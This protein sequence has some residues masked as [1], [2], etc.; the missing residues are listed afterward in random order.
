V[1]LQIGSVVPELLDPSL[2]DLTIGL[3]KQANLADVGRVTVTWQ[4][5]QT[6]MDPGQLGD[7]RTGVDNATAAGV[8]VYLDIYPNGSSQSPNS[9]ADQADFATWAASVVAGLPNV[10][11][12]IVGNESNL[13]LFWL[14]QF[15]S[16]GQDLAATGYIKLLAKTYDA[17]KAVA[18][19]VE[20]VGGALAHSGTDKRSSARQTHSPGQFILDMG[21]AYRALKRTKPIMDAFA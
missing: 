18:P 16:A 12:V 3:M 21:T 13:N 6:A 4:K 15:G 2:Q 5:G 9:P 20:V 17:V 7:L 10:K 8:D 14:P 11:H 1:P 19:A